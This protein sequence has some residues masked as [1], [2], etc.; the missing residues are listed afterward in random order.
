M[1]RSVCKATLLGDLLGWDSCPKHPAIHRMAACTH[2]SAWHSCPHSQSQKPDKDL[3]K[4]KATGSCCHPQLLLPLGRSLLCCV[5]VSCF[6][7][8]CWVWKTTEQFWS[9]LPRVHSWHLNDDKW[10][11]TLSVSQSNWFCQQ[12][13]PDK[14]IREALSEI[15]FLCLRLLSALTPCLNQSWAERELLR[16]PPRWI[17]QHPCHHWDHKRLCYVMFS[18]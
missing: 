7:G 17:V 10:W 5:S 16:H 9:G 14:V 15:L 8:G 6:L 13:D 3:I 1:R 18:S 11:I 2:G 4:H 12:V